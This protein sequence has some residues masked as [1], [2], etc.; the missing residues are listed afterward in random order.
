MS[1]EPK[2]NTMSP[3][4]RV[5]AVKAYRVS[6]ARLEELKAL[7]K[8]LCNKCQGT[9]IEKKNEICAVCESKLRKM[10]VSDGTRKGRT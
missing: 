2:K 3:E 1:E 9:V 4:L 6:K 10:P 7:G 5:M 8:H